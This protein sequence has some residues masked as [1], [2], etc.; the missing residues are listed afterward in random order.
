MIKTDKKLELYIHIPFCVK[1]CRYCDFLSGAYQTDT[2]EKYVNALIEEIRS[3]E[4]DCKDYSVVS[5]F[6]GG[7]T[8]SVLPSASIRRILTEIR[9][10][11]KLVEDCEL[12]I[13]VNPGTIDA[14]KLK[15]YYE[16]GIN[17]ISFGLQSADDDELKMLGRI[18]NYESFLANY[19]AA[20]NIGFDNINVD[21]MSAIPGQNMESLQRT[22]QKTVSL[23]PKPTHISAY[24]LIIEDSTE[25]GTLYEQ[26]RLRVPDEEEDRQMYEFTKKFLA[27]NGYKRYE[28]SNYS[29]PGY[30][31]RHNI[32]YW[33][34][35]EYLGFGIGA[36]SYFGGQRFSNI[37]EIDSYI[38]LSDKC[39]EDIQ[40]L[41]VFDEMEEFMILRLRLTQGAGFDEFYARFNKNMLDVYGSV[42]NKHIKD[43]LLYIYYESG[44][45]KY[46]A[47][48]D[49]GNDISNY[50]LKDFLFDKLC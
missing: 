26:G 20:C 50:V 35:V 30:E 23:C 11:Y 6:F 16:M 36:S 10:G 13:E 17:R 19:E 14:P 31:C 27:Q 7:G 33:T 15:D 9:K 4:N 45:S 47:L 42:I 22:L 25:F 28:I 44:L 3:Y 24:S 46:L 21:I 1:K 5:V 29:L 39:P 34:S 40:K 43:E 18:H 37:K 48:T 12:T 8:P 41:S 2:Q 38:K 32:G 49:K